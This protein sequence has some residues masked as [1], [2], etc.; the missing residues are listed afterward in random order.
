MKYNSKKRTV[1]RVSLT[2]DET[3]LDE[4][5]EKKIRLSIPISRQFEIAYKRY[6]E[7]EEGK[8]Q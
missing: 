5:K 3:I 6:K 1:K 8:C 2:I 7:R 4:T